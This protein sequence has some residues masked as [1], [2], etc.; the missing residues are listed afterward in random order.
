MRKRWVPIL[1]LTAS[2]L[3]GCS[4]L[5]GGKL[6]APETFGLTPVTSNLYVEMGT[7]ESTRDSLRNAMARAEQAIH[8]AYGSVSARPKVHACITEECYAAFGGG[9]GSM[10]KVYGD[11]ILLSPRGLNWH[12]LAHEWSHA[13]M[14][15]RLSFF[16]WKRMPRWFD[17]G[18]AVA[19]SEAPEHSEEHWQYLVASD[20][21]RPTREELHTFKSLRQWVDAIH[22]YGEDRNIERKARGEPEIRPVY[23]AA[24]HE[25][26]P[27][28]LKAGSLGLLAFIA[29][30]ND[31]EDFESAYQTATLAPS[32]SP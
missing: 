8:S 32:P 25:L 31:D 12:L 4:A 24:G 16:A 19:I 28:L 2:F 18:L 9:R 7:D 10:A 11:R 3:S 27:W 20:V 17:E 6:L 26:R 23:S 30:I 1:F 5:Q 13:E 21:P 15:T 29:H 14:S 22:R